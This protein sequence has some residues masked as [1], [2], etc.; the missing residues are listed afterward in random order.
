MKNVRD[1]IWYDIVH[2]KYGEIY[3]SLYISRNR[4]IRKWFKITTILCSATGIFGTVLS[5]KIP[6]I[7]S[8]TIIAII[9]CLTSVESFI[10]HSETQIDE[11]GRL[12]VLYVEKLRQLEKIW[13]NLNAKRISEDNAI[14][15][16][17]N[18][19]AFT[20]EMEKLDDKL[21]IKQHK[22]LKDKAQADTSIYLETYYL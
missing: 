2:T 20:G 18:L 6:T 4:D 5:Q 8:L 21:N 10:I 9:Q 12:R 14:D 13:F 16:F 15:E 17:F 19:R 22:K 11:I 1:S 3:L 7:I